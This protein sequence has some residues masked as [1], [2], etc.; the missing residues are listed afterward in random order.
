[1]SREERRARRKAKREARRA[2]KK[3]RRQK[4]DEIVEAAKVIDFKFDT[5]TE[6]PDF[7]D[8]FNEIWPVLRPTMEYAELIKL[9]GPKADKILRNMVD[10]GHRISTGEASEGE[11]ARFIG[12]LDS[13][14]G[15]VDTSLGIVKTFT[16]DKVDDVIDYILEIGDWLTDNE[17][18]DE[19]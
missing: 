4:F 5:D 3:L 6:D 9:T 10:L 15:I 18:D 8:A 17:D 19:D 1:M 11:E 2:I 13:Y 14:W 7:A 16:P 12:Y